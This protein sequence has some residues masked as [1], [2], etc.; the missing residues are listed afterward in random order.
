[1]WPH[2]SFVGSALALWVCAHHRLPQPQ[3]RPLV[4]LELL[5]W[6]PRAGQDACSPAP[7][8][9]SSH[10]PAGKADAC[11]ALELGLFHFGVDEFGHG[12]G[13]G[14]GH[15]GG[16]DQRCRVYLQGARRGLRHLRARLRPWRVTP[17]R[18]STWP[19]SASEA[20]SCSGLP[21]GSVGG[22]C[23]FFSHLS[24]LW[25]VGQLAWMEASL[26]PQGSQPRRC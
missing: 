20:R 17:G 6:L 19:A 18:P 12:E 22:K 4:A 7:P 23:P 25:H 5:P 9:P 2:S 21:V 10:S 26:E 16:C 13:A 15:H 1:M 24:R 14:C 3:T 11:F 8:S